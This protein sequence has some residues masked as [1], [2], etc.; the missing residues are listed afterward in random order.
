M[1]TIM[2]IIVMMT[3]KLYVSH[4][5]GDYNCC[6]QNRLNI[7]YLRLFY[8]GNDD[9]NLDDNEDDKDES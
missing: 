3:Q 4:I 2:I 6:I 7:R 9:D 8:Y 1:A 5:C